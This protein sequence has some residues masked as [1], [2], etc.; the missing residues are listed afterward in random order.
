MIKIYNNII[1][2]FRNV[3]ALLTI[4]LLSALFIGWGSVGH[5]KISFNTKFSI[6][7]QLSF[8]PAWADSLALHA[9]DADNRKK[10]DPSE[11]PKHFIDIDSYLEFLNT[12]YI[13]HDYDYMV[14]KYGYNTV[15]DNGILPWAILN[16]A[17]SLKEAFKRNDMHKAMLIASDIGHYIAD[18]HMPL[19][20]T[21]NYNGQLT[22]QTGVHLRYE[23]TMIG[24]FQNQ[25]TYTGDNLKYIDNLSD[26]VF[27]M[28]NENYKYVDSVLAADAAAK[29]YAGNTTS[30]TYYNKFW[31][32][33]K[34]FTIRL[35]KS[36]SNKIASV[37]YTEWKN[38]AGNV[39]RVDFKQKNIPTDFILNQNYPNPFNPSTKIT[40]QSPL[41]GWQTLKIYNLLGNEVA[42]LV[43]DYREAGK[44]EVNFDTSNRPGLSSGVYMY[45]LQVGSFISTKKM[46]LLK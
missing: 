12:G 41:A 7:N 22:D 25:I 13:P 40:W 20:I 38:A 34:D 27:N 9:S 30:D 5:N 42:T 46:L 4:T 29:A 26:F 17:D 43:D 24:K 8:F 28:I 36:A 31:E 2:R 11:G 15:I 21:K 33:T 1:K 3:S 39:S 35:F 45:K 19:H 16:A 44:Y 32:L 37:I 6:S 10:A 23:T 18:A 14:T